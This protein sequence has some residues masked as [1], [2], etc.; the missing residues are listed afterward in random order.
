MGHKSPQRVRET[1]HEYIRNIEN[2]IGDPLLLPHKIVNFWIPIKDGDSRV[3]ILYPSTQL[4][5][6]QREKYNKRMSDFL[7][8]E[9]N[10]F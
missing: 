6:Y 7:Y 1:M 8:E 2:S 3:E 9:E 4:S 5:E 10:P